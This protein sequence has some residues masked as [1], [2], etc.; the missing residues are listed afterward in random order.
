ME[1]RNATAKDLDRLVEIHIAAYPDARGVEA[2]RRNFTQHPFGSPR[3]LVVL[4]HEGELVALAFLFPLR[5]AFGGRPVRMGGIGSVGVAP[6]FRGRGMAT[7]LMQHLHVLS[8]ARGDA[9]TMLFPFRQGFYARLDY[10]TTSSRKR[11]AIDTRSIP[12]S[13]RT[14]ARQRVRTVRGNDRSGIR[15]VH[16]R[17]VARSSGWVTR[18][19]P[20]WERLFARERLLFL[21]CEAPL[22]AKTVSGYVAFTV[23]QEHQNA[24]TLIEVEE[25]V[26][27]DGET[28]RALLGALSAMGDQAS[29]I[30]LEVAES[31]PLERAL[32]DPDGRR[33]GTEAV[34]HSVGEIV[35]GPMVRIED[36]PRAIEARGY[37][38]NGSF[39]VVVTEA[40]QPLIAAGVRVREGRAEVGPARGGG[41]LQTTRAGLAALLYGGLSVE[42]A[43]ALGLASAEARLARRLDA[44]L[45]IPPLAPIDA[46]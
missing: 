25:L 9:L 19:K 15:N 42:G 34:E 41:A 38:D 20:L 30:I 44:I 37:A 2:R 5:S 46:F 36:I 6:A 17:A 1:F 10:A 13:W 8:D 23:V 39:D 22:P 18:A 3:H 12:G 16:A 14:V 31:D 27:D 40:S 7:R 26:A 43:I 33:H 32:V 45:R 4:E 11:L 29:E 28:R 21:V 35:A 24:E